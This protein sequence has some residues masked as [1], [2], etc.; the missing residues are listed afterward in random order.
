MRN[1]P[2]SPASREESHLLPD[3]WLKVKTVPGNGNLSPGVYYPT[4]TKRFVDQRT[5]VP[6]PTNT[7]P[8]RSHRHGLSRRS[9]R[10]AILKNGECNILKSRLSQR[11][12][13]FLQDMF[14]TFVD[15]QWRW[16]LLLFT[17]SFIISWLIFALIWWLIAFTH[18]DLEPD[19]LPEMQ[20]SSNW[21]P[22]VLGI[23]GFTS[24]F[25]FSIETQHTI[26]YGARTTTE[27]CPEAIFIMCF[28]SIVGVTIQAF[29]VGIVFA[30]MTRPKQRTQ[31]LLFSKHAVICQR[32]GEL[33]LM[34]RVGDMRKSHI[35]GASV[36]AQLIRSRTTKEGEVLSHY[37]TELELNADGCDSNLF[38]IWPITMV[39]K[40]N[41]DSPFY[42]VSAADILQEKFEI[43]VVLEGTIESTGQTTQAR[44]SY[45]ASELMWGH[46]F[47]PLVTYNRERQGYEV[48]YSKFED[49]MQVDTPLC[50]AKELDEFYGSQ[51]DH[52][53]IG[54]MNSSSTSPGTAPDPITR[55]SDRLVVDALNRASLTNRPSSVKYP[56]DFF[57][58]PHHTSSSSEEETTRKSGKNPAR[59]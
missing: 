33:C 12:L 48:D 57:D 30:K 6:S 11:R 43:V 8:N 16:T 39:H 41:A 53:S 58:A 32:D 17:L 29:T 49:T 26:G 42:R 20:E 27:E 1:D 24:C 23:Y 9:R 54:Y 15:A 37:Q 47:V 38:F 13:R 7:I 40:I 28:Q 4:G 50:S 59:S 3:E 18:G 52:R 34:F 25:L 35:I 45:T 22:C 19:H 14:T 46:R 44:S 31:T 36:R 21:K 5:P 51:A 56:P 55:L 2:E 10:R